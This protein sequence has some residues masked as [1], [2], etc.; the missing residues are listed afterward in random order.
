[1]NQQRTFSIRSRII[2]MNLG[3]VLLFV[4]LIFGLFLPHF[5]GRLLDRKKQSITEIVKIAVTTVEAIYK[6]QQA[7]D[8]SEE[9]AKAQAITIIRSMRY[10]K[11]ELD[12]L[13][14]NNF[15][16]RMI[17][18]PFVPEL[19]GKM[20][21]NY[22]DPNGKKLFVE[23]VRLCKENGRGYLDYEW[24]YKDKAD[25]ILPKVSYVQEFKPWGW[26][27]GTG[28]YIEDV[29]A[30][31]SEMRNLAIFVLALFA[32]LSTTGITLFT[33]R[34]VKPISQLRAAANELANGDLR[35]LVTVS[36]KDEIFLLANDFNRLIEAMQKVLGGLTQHSVQLA[37]STEEMSSTL[38]NFTVQAQN[39]SAST[40]EIAATTEQLSAGMDLV[41]QSSNQQ[42]ES[43][44]SLIGTMQGLSA[45]IGDMGKMVVSAGQKINDINSLAKDGE[46]TLSKLNESMQAV[47]QS[48]TSM[49]SIIEII[50]EISD[51][52]NLLS[53]NAA[54]EAARAGDA[55]RGFAV[56]AEEVGKLADRTGSSIREISELVE[57]N[58]RQIHQGIDQLLA[59]TS[60]I[61]GILS[62]ISGMNSHMTGLQGGMA[63]QT[64]S[65]DTVQRQL[66]VVRTRSDEIKVAIVEQ[67]NAVSEIATSISVINDAIQSVVAASEEMTATS[68]QIAEMA[69]S[70]HD[71]IMFFKL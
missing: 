17:M 51:R 52:I 64:E 12:Y 58:N 55:G 62:G 30:E 42:N 19:N 11:D 16:P 4:V 36:S 8:I 43:V 29:H 10:G 14:I 27:I 61:D 37:S 38:N 68:D 57:T 53:L 5:E 47:L 69:E 39:Q 28:V 48:S 41:Y 70:V 45:K 22:Q 71:Q 46:S 66:G 44:E 54:I 24:Q 49:T 40:E 20:L 7:G 34:I 59:T 33:N 50:N 32:I 23:F 25:Q 9:E 31:M 26:I 67:K 18:H 6:R 15:E 35:E 2:A 1:M 21:D 56:V 63:A 60:V 65:N 3:L 13:W